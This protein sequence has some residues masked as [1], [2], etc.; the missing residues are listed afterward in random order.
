M[1]VNLGQY[2]IIVE[3]ANIPSPVRNK[4][5]GVPGAKAPSKISNIK[6]MMD[7]CLFR[8]F[9]ITSKGR[10]SERKSLPRLIPRDLGS[11]V[12]QKGNP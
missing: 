8:G 1:E 9:A 4:T 6:F 7:R 3:P 2:I 11:G 12:K 5:N 10:S